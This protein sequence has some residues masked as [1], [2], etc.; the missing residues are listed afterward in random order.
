VDDDGLPNLEEIQEKNGFNDGASTD[1]VVHTPQVQPANN[2]HQVAALFSSEVWSD[3]GALKYADECR[4]S[5][6]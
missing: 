5:R 4:I 3:Y 1:S 2:G 6:A